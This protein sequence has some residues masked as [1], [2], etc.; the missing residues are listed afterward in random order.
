[1]HLFTNQLEVIGYGL[2]LKGGM[3]EGNFKKIHKVEW[4][5]ANNQLGQ[6]I[7]LKYWGNE[8]EELLGLP[9]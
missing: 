3:K 4:K 9:R 5:Q 6:E 8:R 7:G 1:M 2:T